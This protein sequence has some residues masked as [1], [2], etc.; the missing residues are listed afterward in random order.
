MPSRPKPRP[1]CTIELFKEA[2]KFSA[3]HFTIFS[4]TERERLHGHD[5]FVSCGLTGTVTADGLIADYG[6]FKRQLRTMCDHLDELLL[7]PGQSPHLQIE[8]S[9]GYVVAIFAGRRMPFLADEVRVLPVA[10]ITLEELSAFLLEQ[11]VGEDGAL[12]R[13]GIQEITLKVSAGPG[14]SATSTR[15]LVTHETPESN[16]A[17]PPG[18]SP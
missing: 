15:S 2:F 17:S 7:L 5:F 1:V 14:Q 16:P 12:A 8:R 18:P 9:D 6:S 13:Q 11:M 10:N 3:A 4:A